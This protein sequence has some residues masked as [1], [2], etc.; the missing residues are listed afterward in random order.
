M[1]VG[2]R[3]PFISCSVGAAAL[4][5]I[6]VGLG[7]AQ[8]GDSRRGGTVDPA[9][10]RKSAAAF[11]GAV[12]AIPADEHWATGFLR[13][14]GDDDTAFRLFNKPKL[15]T[16]PGDWSK[17]TT[18]QRTE[19]LAD[20]SRKMEPL[21]LRVRTPQGG[22]RWVYLLE[23]KVGG[24][25]LKDTKS[26]PKGIKV[27]V[28][29]RQQSSTPPSKAAPKPKSKAPEPK[30]ELFI[31]EEDAQNPILRKQRGDPLPAMSFFVPIVFPGD[32]YPT[33]KPENYAPEFVEHLQ[34]LGYNAPRGSLKGLGRWAP[35]GTMLPAVCSARALLIQLGHE[36]PAKR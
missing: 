20:S 11:N 3:P 19:W 29:P 35:G 21:L 12:A 26:D 4:L 31:L 6:L 10:A 30:W 2:L 9:A 27:D 22:M 14:T 33:L 1:P 5:A 36:L 24:M 17:F 16:L 25:E 32:G 15:P 7:A 34:E 18:L 8:S 13:L 28:G 23:V